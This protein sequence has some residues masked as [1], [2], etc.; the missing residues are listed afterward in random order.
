M[1]TPPE[2][3]CC[4][5]E[6]HP[7]CYF[8]A[9]AQTEIPGTSNAAVIADGAPLSIVGLQI[10]SGLRGQPLNITG[11]TAKFGPFLFRWRKGLTRKMASKIKMFVKQKVCLACWFFVSKCEVELNSVFS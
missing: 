7:K 9:K 8:A 4:V 5:D 10:G 11:R 1:D 6:I 2:C 3:Y